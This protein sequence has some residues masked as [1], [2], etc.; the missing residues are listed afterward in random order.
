MVH[1]GIGGTYIGFD[2][3]D[4]DDDED[5]EEEDANFGDTA[6]NKELVKRLLSARGMDIGAVEEVG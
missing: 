3:D 5:E 1:P 4:D 6:K 2:E